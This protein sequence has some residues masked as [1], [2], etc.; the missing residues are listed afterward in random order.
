MVQDWYD[1]DLTGVEWTEI[2]VATLSNDRLGEVG[3]KLGLDECASK[4]LHNT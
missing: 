4:L 3:F 2:D 1:T